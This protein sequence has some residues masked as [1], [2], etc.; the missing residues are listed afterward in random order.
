MCAHQE[1]E[2]EL[3]LCVL[4]AWCADHRLMSACLF[5]T[6]VT[7]CCCCCELLLQFSNSGM[8]SDIRD[9]RPLSDIMELDG[10]SL[11]QL[12]TLTFSQLK[13]LRHH[14]KKVKYFLVAAS[15]SGGCDALL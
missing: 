10:P 14:P 4:S 12:A 1:Q 6:A 9:V 8:L 7:V 13:H 11:P 3:V 5:G 15:P 2:V